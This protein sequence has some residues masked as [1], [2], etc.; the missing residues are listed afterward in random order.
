VPRH[1]V[2]TAALGIDAYVAGTVKAADEAAVQEERA[3]RV[4]LDHEGWVA[5]AS[6]AGST[7]GGFDKA[8]G[9][10]AI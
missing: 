8:G 6:F 2:D 4:P 3:R 7:G 10:S 5:V 9:R 1:A